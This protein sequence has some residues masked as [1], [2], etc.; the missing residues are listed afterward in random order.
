MKGGPT[1]G[2]FGV[3]R[4]RWL[5][6]PARD[7]LANA[8]KHVEML[9]MFPYPQCAGVHGEPGH[10]IPTSE[11]SECEFTCPGRFRCPPGRSGAGA[12]GFISRRDT[13]A[14]RRSIL[15]DHSVGF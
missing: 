2:E 1:L 3:V 4:I 7:A 6:R 9:E 8:L 14:E 11:R 15:R 12:D 5:P 13:H 10:P